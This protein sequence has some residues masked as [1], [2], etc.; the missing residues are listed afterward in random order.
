MNMSQSG[1]YILTGVKLCPITGLNELDED[2]LKEIRLQIGGRRGKKPKSKADNITNENA[3][4]RKT[5]SSSKVEESAQKR[6]R[7]SK[8]T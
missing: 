4:S 1:G 6:Q 7:T 5:K 3:S 8:T 2:L